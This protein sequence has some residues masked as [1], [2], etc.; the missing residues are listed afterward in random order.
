MKKF[1]NVFFAILLIFSFG[2][3]NKF[4]LASS[5]TNASLS[6]INTTK[7]PSLSL[8]DNG[9]NAKK[10]EHNKSDGNLKMPI[11]SSEEIIMSNAT[12]Y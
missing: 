11:N 7:L 1:I 2:I 3:I 5:L 4:E 10:S 8:Q 6:N 9:S 12:H